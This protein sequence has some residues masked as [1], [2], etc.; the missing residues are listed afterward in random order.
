MQ[1]SG[2]TTLEGATAPYTESWNYNLKICFN[3]GS[4]NAGNSRS[5]TIKVGNTTMSSSALISKLNQTISGN[6]SSGGAVIVTDA[7]AYGCN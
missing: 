4:V 1:T 2:E 3:L 7:N 5:L 6:T